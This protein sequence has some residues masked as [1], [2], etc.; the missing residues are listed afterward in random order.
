VKTY[1]LTVQSSSRD[2]HGSRIAPGIRLSQAQDRPAIGQMMMQGSQLE[3]HH[4]D[5]RVI[6]TTLLTYGVSVREEGGYL[7]FA[8]DPADPEIELTLPGD[9]AASDVVAGT[10][11]WLV[12]D[13]G[14]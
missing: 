12:H 5:G 14:T 8:G 7:Y 11:I 1:I 4:P 3:L 9:V 2:Q 10:E 13:S 6:H